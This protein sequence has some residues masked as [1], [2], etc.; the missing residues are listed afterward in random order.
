MEI[1]INIPNFNENHGLRFEWED[2]FE[3]KTSISNGV[4]ILSANKEGL[5]SLAKQLLTL[6][7]ENVPIGHH[8]H[9][10]DYNSL[11]E[12]SKELIIEKI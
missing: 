1:S 3:I 9:Y 11:D 12:N 4:I 6:A 7:Q 8:M 5:I 2:G 10:D